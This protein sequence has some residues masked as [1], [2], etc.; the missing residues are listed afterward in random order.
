MHT[1][2]PA[3]KVLIALLLHRLHTAV[4]VYFTTV[5][6]NYSSS[7]EITI[8]LPIQLG[9]Q[10]T[11]QLPKVATEQDARVNIFAF[12]NTW[13]DFTCIMALSGTAFMSILANFTISDNISRCQ[14]LLNFSRIS[15]EF[16]P[17]SGI[18]LPGN[19]WS[20]Q[21]SKNIW[22]PLHISNVCA[23][24]MS[25]GLMGSPIACNNPRCFLL[26]I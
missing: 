3:L 24:N 13:V 4:P 22:G 8:K 15:T 23:P 17:L 11:V 16:L 18:T 26:T 5:S 20:Q 10:D 7:T 14:A 6:P 21:Q 12:A 9:L 2:C 19:S 1:F 25:W